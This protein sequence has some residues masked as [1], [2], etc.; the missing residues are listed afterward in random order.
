V[1]NRDSTTSRTIGS[2]HSV[3]SGFTILLFGTLLC[4]GCG[5]GPQVK[6]TADYRA[7]ALAGSRVAFVPLAV[8]DDLGDKRTG[9]VLS[10]RTRYYASAAACTRIAESWSDGKVVCLD[11]R[12]AAQA[13]VLAELERH[14][15]LDEPVPERVWQRVREV[16]G[17][18]YAMLF[19]PE[20]VSSSRE[21]SEELIGSSGGLV[22][23]GPLLATSALVS[24]IIAGS[25]MHT[26]TV[27]DTELS[28]TV[29]ASLVDIQSGKL[30]KVGVHS[31]ADSHK[32]ERQLGYAEAPP[33]A[34]ILEG[35]M[36]GLGETL[37]DDS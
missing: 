16:S 31:G 7:R 34:P 26:V 10:A 6:T 32:T 19:R 17:A 3:T 8:S 36:V 9:I 22:G 11:P 13:S 15:A 33:A 21:S 1:T 30:L 14:F 18:K 5:G 24:L 20:S 2:A 27:S 29:S 23:S 28:Y 37:L 25:T 35:I 4:A 12:A